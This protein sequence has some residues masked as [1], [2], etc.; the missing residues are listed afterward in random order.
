VIISQ[1]GIGDD[2]NYDNFRQYMLR[3]ADKI[4]AAHKETDRDKSTALWRE[5]FGD[6]FKPGAVV[7]KSAETR[8]S[9]SL[10]WAAEGFIDLP[11]FGFPLKRSTTY[12]VKIEARVT[13]LKSGQIYRHNGFRQFTLSKNGNRVPKNRSIRFTATTNVPRPYD[14]Y[15]KVRN[16][17]DEAAAASELRG[18]I[19]KDEGQGERVES[20][21]CRLPLR[22]GLCRH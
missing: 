18:E 1:I 19:R 4:D 16:G 7:T 5:V 17:G 15:W 20:T 14:L 22:R 13:G 9:A 12:Q 2:W 10:P 3:Y 6:E 21:S 8:L 11:P